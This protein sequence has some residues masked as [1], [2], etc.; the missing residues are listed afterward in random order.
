MIFLILCGLKLSGECRVNFKKAIVLLLIVSSLIGLVTPQK[1]EAASI[2]LMIIGDSKQLSLNT[3]KTIKWSTTNSSV[4]SVNNNGKVVAKGMGVAIV[5][6]HY[7]DTFSYWAFKVTTAEE[8]VVYINDISKPVGIITEKTTI[9]IGDM[10]LLDLNGV[11]L[12]NVKWKSSN[13]NIASVAQD[14]VVTGIK[15][16]TVTITATVDGVDYTKKIK[17]NTIN[18]TPTPKSTSI[19]NKDVK[20]NAAKKTLHIGQNYT[21]KITGTTQK[22]MWKSNNTSV[23][24]VNSSG[25]VTAVGEGTATIIATIGSG[26]ENIKLT[27]KITVKNRLSVDKTKV[28][29]P[30]DEYQEVLLTFKNSKEDEVISLSYDG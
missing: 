21:V 1:T 24:T 2:Y 13:K 6:A 9:N 16:G 23:A 28:Y 30:L 20:I 4:I 18:P 7:G 12:K 10:L 25:K 5:Y 29:C 26:S 19:S 3:T 14:G 27:C 8:E 15:E 11:S 17:V 22:I